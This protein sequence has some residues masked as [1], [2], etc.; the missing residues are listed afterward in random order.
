MSKY[1]RTT[2]DNFLWK[3]GAILEKTKGENGYSP[4]EDLWDVGDNQD[5]YISSFIVE[6]RPDW[7][8]RVYKNKFD[9]FLTKSQAVLK[10]ETEIATTDKK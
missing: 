3:K 4:V 7:F 5:E 2:K 9:R 10:F 1:Y 6:N 8:E